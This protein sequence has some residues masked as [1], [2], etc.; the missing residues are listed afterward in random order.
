LLYGGS[1]GVPFLLSAEHGLD[2]GIIF[3]VLSAQSKGGIMDRVPYGAGRDFTP[4]AL[5]LHGA[6]GDIFGVI[7]AHSLDGAPFLA[8]Y[9]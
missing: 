5:L 9:F 2:W 1:G 7:P 6:G 8:T 4:E 3:A